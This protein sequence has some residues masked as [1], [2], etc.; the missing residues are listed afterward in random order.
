MT[1]LSERQEEGFLTSRFI[2]NKL[3]QHMTF[4]NITY[5]RE[6]K[7]CVRVITMTQNINSMQRRWSQRYLPE[8][9]MNDNLC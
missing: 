3:K 4:D 5:I 8:K 9:L 1:G 7:Q 2:F 6:V